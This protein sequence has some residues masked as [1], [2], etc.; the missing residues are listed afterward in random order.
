MTGS[1]DQELA[2]RVREEVGKVASLL[3]RRSVTADAHPLSGSEG[4]ESTY[5]SS[6]LASKL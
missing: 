6:A 3:P 2:G 5:L 1:K 4:C